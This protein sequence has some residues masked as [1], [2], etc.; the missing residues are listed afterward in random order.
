MHGAG[1]RRGGRGDGRDRAGRRVPREVRWRPHRRRG[2]G[3][4]PLPGT[5]RLGQVEPAL[6]SL[7]ASWAPA[8]PRR[9]APW[10]PSWA[11]P[12][13][14]SDHEIERELGEPIESWFDRNG[15]AA[16]RR[17]EEDIVLGLLGAPT[18]AYSRWVAARS[19]RTVCR[20][21]Y[22]ATSWS[23]WTW[24]PSRHGGAV[25][26]GARWRVIASASTSCTRNAA[27]STSSSRTHGCPPLT[28][29]PHATPC[30]RSARWLAPI[31]GRSCCGVLLRPASTRCSSGTVWSPRASSIPSTGGASS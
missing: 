27:R 5:N 9:R 26:A 6:S 3:R 31:R 4:P 10:R 17:V 23:T 28:V 2:R 20:T 18:C 22:A 1:G 11:C 24:T 19:A 13:V 30:R 12:L 29:R 21:P 15:E 16:F 8:S 14:D 25:A 7:P